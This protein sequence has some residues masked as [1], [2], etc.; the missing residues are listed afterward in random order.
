V[1][2][3]SA[4]A[5]EVHLEASARETA[6]FGHDVARLTV[7]S[8]WSRELDE[9][10]LGERVRG[11]LTATSA[12]T[13][14]LRYPSQAAFLVKTLGDHGRRVFPAASLLYWEHRGP[15]PSMPEGVRMLAPSDLT[16]EAIADVREVIADSFAGYIN[17]YSANPLIAPDAV[18]EG[19]IEWAESTVSSVGNRVF[20]LNTADRCV[21]V[22]TVECPG[23]EAYWEIQLAG[24]HSDYQRRG[25]YTH[26][27]EAVL[28]SAED[29]GAERV[30]ISTQAHNINVQR[31]WARLGFI[32]FASIDTVHLV[33]AEGSA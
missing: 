14:I 19:Y 27:V 17:H 4:G 18:A 5:G 31:A 8:E 26:L 9:N 7:G 25:H 29:A 6:R 20:L 12:Q 11:L 30:V 3:G 32:P 16:P 1:T 22:A 33:A 15:A 28:A 2:W 21:G 13:V 10:H 24:I 23:E